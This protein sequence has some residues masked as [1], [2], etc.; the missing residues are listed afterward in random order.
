MRPHEINCFG[1]SIVEWQKCVGHWPRANKKWPNA[2]PVCSIASF[3]LNWNIRNG[4]FYSVWDG[5]CIFMAPWHKQTNEQ[6][7]FFHPRIIMAMFAIWIEQLCRCWYSEAEFLY[8]PLNK[9]HSKKQNKAKKKIKQRTCKHKLEQRPE[10]GRVIAN[11]TP[12]FT[13]QLRISVPIRNTNHP[14]QSSSSTFLLCAMHTISQFADCIQY[15]SGIC[16]RLYRNIV[17]NAEC[18]VDRRD[19]VVVWERILKNWLQHNGTQN[20][21][22]HTPWERTRMEDAHTLH[23]ALQI[24]SII[25]VAQIATAPAERQWTIYVFNHPWMQ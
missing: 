3:N 1:N 13:Y 7:L 11:R 22:K 6:Q 4:Y 18:V 14:F 10:S 24:I 5:D 16:A 23:G 19:F 15:C 2:V 9:K 8:I 25:F 20:Q 17:Q 12:T 21:A